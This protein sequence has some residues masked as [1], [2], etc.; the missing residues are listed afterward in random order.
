MF[1][2]HGYKKKAYDREATSRIGLEWATMFDH[3]SARVEPNATGYWGRCDLIK[4]D[5]N[6]DHAL[7]RGMEILRWSTRWT[8][9]G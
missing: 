4:H 3:C 2:R 6:V 7:E 5:Q 8:S 1:W 9:S